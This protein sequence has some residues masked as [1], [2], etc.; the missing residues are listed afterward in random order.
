MHESYLTVFF[1]EMN[2]NFPNEWCV[3]HSYET[4]PQ[5]SAS[6]VD[7]AFSG[8]NVSSLEILIVEVGNKTGWQL[9]Q[10][11]WYDV[12]TCFYYVLKQT[13]ADVFLALDF[14]IDNK[15]I[16]RYGFKTSMLTNQC[17]MTPNTFPVPNPE[18]AFS[19]KLIKRIVKKR[20]LTEDKPYLMQQYAKSNG[21]KI[22]E[23]LE[24]QFGIRGS[25]LIKEFLTAKENTLTSKEI[26]Y[27]NTERKRLGSNFK[28]KLSYVSWQLK[29][30]VNRVFYPSGM[31]LY[32][33]PLNT[34]ELA[35][36]THE[37]ET[38]VGILFRFTRSNPAR[39][40]KINFTS[41]VGS[42]LVLCPLRHHKQ[43]KA[44]QY[45]WFSKKSLDVDL[46]GKHDI[47]V[48]ADLYYTSI[49]QT[50]WDRI[51]DRTLSS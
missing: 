43:Q 39:S 19:Y 49:L 36:L 42:T 21:A 22:Q 25:S 48:M 24:G 34:D 29:R 37:L 40:Y 18:V 46:E 27:V 6:D 41:F 13:D 1:E 35:L 14:L 5:Y 23:F 26:A 44:I 51:A 47:K 20:S 2:R 17:V 32:T 4:L 8:T 30:I 15:G 33:P 10:K 9:Y 12:E 3:L 45:T 38:R 11:L 7:M 31:I 28:N 50:L 16:G